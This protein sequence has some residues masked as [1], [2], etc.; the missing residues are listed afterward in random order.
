MLNLDGTSHNFLLTVLRKVGQ[1]S[2]LRTEEE[3]W[4]WQE[5]SPGDFLQIVLQTEITFL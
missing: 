5:L 4:P 3:S 2:L 1:Y